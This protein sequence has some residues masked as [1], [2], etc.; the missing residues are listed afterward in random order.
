MI[1]FEPYDYI[2][3]VSRIILIFDSD[4]LQKFFHYN[5]SFTLCYTFALIGYTIMTLV[6]DLCMLENPGNY[7]Y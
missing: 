6:Y 5:V 7:N 1:I 3:N 2:I 4:D